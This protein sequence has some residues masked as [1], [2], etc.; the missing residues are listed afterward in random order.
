MDACQLV[1]EF[2]GL[3]PG[4]PEE[5]VVF[6]PCQTACG[7]EVAG[8][9]MHK[10]TFPQGVWD[11]YFATSAASCAAACTANADRCVAALWEDAKEAPLSDDAKCQLVSSLSG[12][13]PGMADGV[14]LYIA[15]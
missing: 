12:I 15:C 11:S 14:S 13:T 10:K 6:T 4:M 7:R 3:V 1:F 9:E 8:Y 2:T 5:A